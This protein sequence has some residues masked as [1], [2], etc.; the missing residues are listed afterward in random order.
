MKRLSIILLI[1]FSTFSVFGQQKDSLRNDS[2]LNVQLSQT[3]DLLKQ[4]EKQTIVDSLRRQ[5]LLDE[6]KA[7]SSDDEY[8]RSILETQ[9]QKQAEEDSI[10]RAKLMESIQELKKSTREELK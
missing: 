9:L 1:L 8:R 4:K 3:E 2:L 10:R 7:L 5:A 6:L